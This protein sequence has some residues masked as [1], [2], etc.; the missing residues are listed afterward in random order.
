MDKQTLLIVG[1]VAVGALFLLNRGGSSSAPA[2]LPGMTGQT[3]LPQGSANQTASD[4]AQWFD[5][6]GR[7][8]TSAANAYGAVRAQIQGSP[9]PAPAP[10]ARS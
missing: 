8:A 10:A 3:P 1:V 5:A 7:A 6:L 4:F 9:A 2:G